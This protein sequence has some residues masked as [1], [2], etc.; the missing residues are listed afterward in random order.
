MSTIANAIFQVA[1]EIASNPTSIVSTLAQKLP[2]AATFFITYIMLQATISAALELLQI[3]PLI[4]SWVFSFLASTPR[5][6]WGQKGGCPST[7]LGTLIPSHTVIF[8]LGEY[9]NSIRELPMAPIF[10]CNVFLIIL[11]LHRSTLLHYRSIGASFRPPLLHHSLLCL[12][13]SVLVCV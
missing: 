8:V 5:S 1:E 13:A 7:N 11:L 12:L 3:V 4:L 10:Q 6:I 9:S 2:Q